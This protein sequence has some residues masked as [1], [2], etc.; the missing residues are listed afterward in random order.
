MI[1]ARSALRVTCNDLTHYGL[2]SSFITFNPSKI[3]ADNQI[4]GVRIAF[5]YMTPNRIHVD[6]VYRAKVANYYYSHE[7]DRPTQTLIK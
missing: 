6:N 4:S 7:L 2:L 3:T 5:M 1:V